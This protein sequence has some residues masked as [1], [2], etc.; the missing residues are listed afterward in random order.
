MGKNKY[1]VD[2]ILLVIFL[3]YAKAKVSSVLPHFFGNKYLLLSR[4][5]YVE[6]FL[7]RVFSG[8]VI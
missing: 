4:L 2:G 1:L 3:V 5:P 7:L 6:V 8:G